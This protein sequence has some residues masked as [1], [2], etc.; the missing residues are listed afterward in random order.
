MS[1]INYCKIAS[2]IHSQEKSFYLF[3]RDFVLDNQ[4]W[5]LLNNLASHDHVFILSGIIRDFLT[6]DYN[7]ARDFDCVLLNGTYKNSEVIHFLR[8]SSHSVNNFGGLKIKRPHEKIDVWRMADTWGIRNQ[9]VKATPQSLINS[10]FF[11][12]SAIVYDFNNKKFIFNDIFCDFLSTNTMDIVYQENPN[13]PLCLVN[14]LYYHYRYNYKISSNIV[15]WIC[16]HY[17]SNMDFRLIQKK[18]FGE[19]LFSNEDIREIFI[20]LTKKCVCIK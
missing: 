10:V 3:I 4:S 12:F 16:K 20:N 14:I 9:G 11:N 17:K 1:S 18:H 6:G 8:E 19:Q 2:R 13:I 15:L 7:G 5:N